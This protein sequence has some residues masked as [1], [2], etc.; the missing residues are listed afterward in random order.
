MQQVSEWSVEC[1][2]FGQNQ[3]KNLRRQMIS[4]IIQN[5]LQCTLHDT[6]FLSFTKFEADHIV[7]EE[8]CSRIVD[9]Y[10]VIIKSPPLI[11]DTFRTMN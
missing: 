1:A 7:G 11:A 4:T 9:A 5:D 6:V 10:D 2:D 3:M 8:F